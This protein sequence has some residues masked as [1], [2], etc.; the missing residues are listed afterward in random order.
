MP[1]CFQ[2][3]ASS[4]EEDET[5]TEVLEYKVLKSGKQRL[6]IKWCSGRIST[7]DYENVDIDE[8]DMV[9]E[10]MEKHHATMPS[11]G[12]D[13]QE[14]QPFVCPVNHEEHLMGTN[15]QEETNPMCCTGQF[16]MN[17]DCSSCAVPF[18]HDGR[19]EPGVRFKPSYKA[20]IFA[21]IY[22]T[23]GCTWALCTP[24]FA[25]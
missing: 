11:D 8:P 14:D 4:D 15:Y 16:D 10:F 17:R 1:Y 3:E 2:G 18:V 12:D 25:E 23:K 9:R 24:C 6:R 7:E 20:P 13:E 22:R 5:I 19:S 21:C